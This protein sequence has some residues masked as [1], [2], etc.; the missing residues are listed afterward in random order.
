M[1]NPQIIVL[2]SFFVR[3]Q[4]LLEPFI[5]EIVKLD[6]LEK[7]VSCCQIVPSELGENIGDYAAVAIALYNL[8][9]TSDSVGISGTRQKS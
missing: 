5:S 3:C 8:K 4:Q 2:G 6:A 9:S 1:R 7:S